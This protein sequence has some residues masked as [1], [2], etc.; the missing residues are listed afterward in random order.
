MLVIGFLQ[1][2]RFFCWWCCL[3]LL[4]DTSAEELLE[5][6]LE[7]EDCLLL[8]TE[9]VLETVEAVEPVIVVLDLVVIRLLMLSALLVPSV[10]E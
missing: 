6:E 8:R 10:L 3:E 1:D 9:G 4:G 2:R 7:D 5:D